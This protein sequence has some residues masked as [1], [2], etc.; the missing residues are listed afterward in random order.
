[1]TTFGLHT[2]LPRSRE[3]T[4]TPAV[5]ADHPHR[6]E[7]ARRVLNVVVAAVGLVLTAPVMLAIA[8]VIKLTS[9]G[10]VFYRQ[11]RVGLCLRSSVGGNHRRKVDLG[12][13]PFT[14]F[15]F[16]TMRPTKPGE[17][18]QTWAAEDDPRITKVGHFL[19][20]TRLDE[21]PQL[22]NVLRG[23]M[24]VVGPRP[25][26]PSIFQDLRNE[27]TS[28]AARQRVRPGITGRAQI[29]LHYDTCVD[30]VR[31]KVEADLEYIRTQSLLEDLRI[32]ALTAPVMV[33]RKGSR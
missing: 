25:E 28:Y 14:I 30:D 9:P 20:R 33:F 31:K 6:R 10:P 8:I 17:E 7:R 26:Q 5:P 29:T 15:K 12:G 27:V 19:R 16:R 11:T 1:M 4:R 2:V 13:R 23:E 22:I 21:L 32:M 24:N 18:I 3:I